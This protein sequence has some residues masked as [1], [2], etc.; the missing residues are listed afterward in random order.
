MHVNELFENQ[1]NEN[2]PLL[3]STHEFL[4]V[5]LQSLSSFS[6]NG[7]QYLPPVLCNTCEFH[8]NWQREGCIFLMGINVIIYYTYK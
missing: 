1:H 2:H 7:T 8:K 5:V 6:E 3:S 4:T